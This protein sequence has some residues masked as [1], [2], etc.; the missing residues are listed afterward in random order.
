MHGGNA[1]SSPSREGAVPLLRLTALDTSGTGV[2]SDVTFVHRLNTVGGVAPAGTC[3]QA[4]KS[5]K[6]VFYSATYYFY[7]KN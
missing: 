6:N 2:F 5:F 1:V 4:D 7:K 3:D